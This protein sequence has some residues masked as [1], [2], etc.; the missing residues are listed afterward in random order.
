MHFYH[1]FVIILIGE[2]MKKLFLTIILLASIIGLYFYRETIVEYIIDN[3]I[4][5]KVVVIQD[6]NAYKTNNIYLYVK[7]TN[8]FFVENKQDFLN[9]FYTI[10]NNGWEEFSFYCHDNYKNC[11]EEIRELS[12]DNKILS[13]INNFVHPFNSYKQLYLSIDEGGKI[14]I[15]IDKLYTEEEIIRINNEVDY[16]LKNYTNDSMSV[17]EKIKTIHD[18]I[19]D[20]T[21]Y[22]SKG[23]DLVSNYNV[24]T[25][26]NYKSHKATGPIETKKALC[27]GYTDYMALFLHKLGIKNY[28]VASEKHVWNLVYL[29]DK[30]YHLDLTWDD[31]VTND[32]NYKEQNKYKFFLI[33]TT[34]LESYQTNQHN[35]DKTI[36]LEAN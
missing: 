8:N 29:N 9:V 31:P 23:A 3:F 22:D 24:V 30:W 20:T 12:S 32:L 25:V 10:L 17:K 26:G 13:N 34:T 14:T 16:V 28:K 18:Y 2:I 4:F 27:G 19:I 33:D 36:Y 1:N 15:M 11:E 6:A 5:K 35:Y 7:D 21:E